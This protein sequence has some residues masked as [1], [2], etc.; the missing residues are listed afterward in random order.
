MTVNNTIMPTIYKKSWIVG[1]TDTSAGIVP[2][3]ATGLDMA[4]RLGAV[5]VRLGLRRMRYMIDSGKLH[6]N[7][8]IHVTLKEGWKE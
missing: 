7:N 8:R 5:K 4:D 1:E 6:N 2:R 3:V